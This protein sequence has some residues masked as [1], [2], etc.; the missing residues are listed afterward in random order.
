[1]RAGLERPLEQFLMTI[2][3]MIYVS[4]ACKMVR[5]IVSCQDSGFLLDFPSELAEMTVENTMHNATQ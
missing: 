1:M 4:E 3:R 2:A 5:M